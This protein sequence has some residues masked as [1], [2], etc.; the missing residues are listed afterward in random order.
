VWLG[1]WRIKMAAAIVMRV[2]LP[3]GAS[4]EDDQ[5]MLNEFVIPMVKSQVGFKNGTWVHDGNRNGLGVIVFDTEEHATGA[6]DALKP[7]AGGPELLSSDLY[8]VG[9]QA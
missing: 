5:K 4:H 2:K 7:P 9:G 6:Q 1:D 8:Q 3:E